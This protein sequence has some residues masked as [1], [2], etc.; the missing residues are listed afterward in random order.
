VT[1]GV[2]E[3]APGYGERVE[4]IPL[5]WLVGLAVILVLLVIVSLLFFAI[6]NVR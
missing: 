6:A 1:E 4:R 5:R 3:A 2:T